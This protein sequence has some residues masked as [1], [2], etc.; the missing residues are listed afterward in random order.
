MKK[1]VK[2]PKKVIRK[3]GPLPKLSH[4]KCLEVYQK[5]KEGVRRK[6]IST[7][8]G[9][10]EGTIFSITKRYKSMEQQNI[11]LKDETIY[12]TTNFSSF[13]EKL[14]DWCLEQETKD[15][16][17]TWDLFYKAAH[18]ISTN[19]KAPTNFRK[20]LQKFLKDYN[21]QI[22]I[23][24]RKKRIIKLNPNFLKY[25]F[26][27]HKEMDEQLFNWLLE[28][29]ILRDIISNELNSLFNDKI[30]K[31]LSE[32]GKSLK[33]SSASR[34]LWEFKKCHEIL[35]NF[36]TLQNFEGGDETKSIESCE[37]YTI[38]EKQL[39]KWLIEQKKLG[40]TISH[41][42]LRDE[43]LKLIIDEFE[44]S[45]EIKEENWLWKIGQRYFLPKFYT[46]KM[47]QCQIQTIKEKY[48][49]NRF[50]NK[51]IKNLRR[52]LKKGN[53]NE[54]NI[55][56]VMKTYVPWQN[57]IDTLV[58]L[59]NDNEINI[60]EVNIENLRTPI[61]T[62]FCIHVAG[63][64]KFSPYFITNK[65]ENQSLQEIVA[66]ETTDFANWYNDTFK[67]TL[68]YHRLKKDINDKVFLFAD[69]CMQYILWEKVKQNEDFKIKIIPENIDSFFQLMYS[70]YEGQ[71]YKYIKLEREKTSSVAEELDRNY[72]GDFYEAIINVIWNSIAE[73]EK[74]ELWRKF[75]RQ[76]S[77]KRKDN[78]LTTA[79]FVDYITKVCI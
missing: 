23:P 1:L 4:Q 49:R 72:N 54:D 43:T 28:R 59:V 67:T 61:S 66:K 10:S 27:K 57:Y 64:H 21:I 34:W 9:V 5:V 70:K 75:L 79:E 40:Y 52:R 46:F 13:D 30:R 68:R 32:Y 56:Y 74:K 35:I 63:R 45:N 50:V 47:F 3:K 26:I 33:I 14:H 37:Q 41:T 48:E 22:K 11:N 62:I 20:S 76:H 53:L 2:S 24:T 7:E 36:V 44:K 69:N 29:I 6:E 65:N 12:I 58:K 51:Y 8:Y 15:V 42:M 17:I 77:Q 73:D 71:I 55:Y 16:T 39:F 60:R 18:E 78:P 38:L 19:T 31:L 25:H